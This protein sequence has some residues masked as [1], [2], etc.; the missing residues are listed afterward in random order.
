MNCTT[1]K[2]PYHAVSK[3]SNGSVPSYVESAHLILLLTKCSDKATNGS[4]KQ[5]ASAS[6][7]HSSK[8][9]TEANAGRS[10]W[11]LTAANIEEYNSTVAN[12]SKFED[13]LS[14]LKVI[15]AAAWSRGIDFSPSAV[16]Y[17]LEHPRAMN[18]LRRFIMSGNDGAKRSVDHGSWNELV[19]NWYSRDGKVISARRTI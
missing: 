17:W 16:Q 12:T 14:D 19:A 13:S 3:H 10:G 11:P 1:G 2:T 18:R 4:I 8:Q 9:T 5:S 15:R 7:N 6:N